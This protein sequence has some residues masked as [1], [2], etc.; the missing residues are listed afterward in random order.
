MACS[1]TQSTELLQMKEELMKT[2][3]KLAESQRAR[4]FDRRF[5]M[6]LRSQMASLRNNN[7]VLHSQASSLEYEL[8]SLTDKI[9]QGTESMWRWANAR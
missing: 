2:K 1:A 9:F 4:E 5:I 8:E 7:E 6:G 3:A